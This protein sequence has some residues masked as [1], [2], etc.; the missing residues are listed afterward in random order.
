MKFRNR[1][2]HLLLTI[3]LFAWVTGEVSA[4]VTPTKQVQPDYPES[5]QEQG[6]AGQALIQVTIG[7]DGKVT[8]A[9]VAKAS[10]PDFGEAALEAA[11][12][13]EFKPARRMGKPVKKVVKIPFKF[14][15]PYKE[16]LN[17]ELGRQVF[18][19]LDE[20]RDVIDL[21]NIFEEYRPKPLV[22]AEPRYPESL[23]G[24]GITGRVTITYIVD[25]EGKV[26]NP[27]VEA[28]SNPEFVMPALLAAM[29]TEWRPLVQSGG[30]IAYQRVT[31][32]YEFAEP[33]P[34]KARSKQPKEE[35]KKSGEGVD[36]EK[37]KPWWKIR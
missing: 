15:V 26:R 2:S 5:L 36:A 24:S 14:Q 1:S 37:K 18:G 8:A 7:K 28:A 23:V 10:H 22:R 29:M 35:K 16:R 17:R 12:K 30:K 13:W 4:Q 33:K 34:G 19:P 31:E 6:I 9:E 3:L 20:D 21:K 11:R 27:V 32:T 25:E